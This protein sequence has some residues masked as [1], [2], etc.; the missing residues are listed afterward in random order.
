[1]AENDQRS[2][3]SLE[4]LD[5]FIAEG[6]SGEDIRRH[7]ETCPAC[8]DAAARLKANAAFLSSLPKHIG[9]ARPAPLTEP[10]LEIEGYEILEEIHRGGQGVV[11]RAIQKATN[12]TVALKIILSGAFATSR[13][14]HRFER[15]VELAAALRHSNI[16][17]VHDSGVSR[18]GRLYLAMELIDGESLDRFLL[19]A[20][21]KHIRD[22]LRLFSKICAA[23]AYAHQRG[24][25]HR[26]LKPGNIL[27]DEEGEP[28]IVD[29]GLAKGIEADWDDASPRVTM[30]GEFMGTLAYS[31]PE[32]VGG[33][34]DAIDVR[35]D[36]YSL[37]VI[38]YEALTGRHPYPVTGRLADVISAIAEAE[39]RPPSTWRKRP[40]RTRKR[41]AD[42]S[43]S[44]R[45]DDEI[46]TIILK[47]LA[48]DKERRYQSADHLKQDLDHYLAGE[49]I[50]AKRDSGWYVMRKAI[51]RHRGKFASAAAL[52]VLLIGFAVT[53]AVQRQSIAVE[54]D[55]ARTEAAKA[56]QINDFL[57]QMLASVDPVTARGRDVTIL[58]ELLD[59][60]ATRIE[61][62]LIGQPEVEAAVRNVIG[63]TYHA[64]GLYDE[65]EPHLTAAFDT[66]R[67]LKGDEHPDTLAVMHNLAMLYRAQGRYE[68]AEPVNVAVFEARRD[69]LGEEHPHTL[70]A[71]NE[72]ALL[73]S[74]QGRFDE[75]ERLHLE[76]DEIS[77]RVLGAD[78]PDTLTTRHNLANLYRKMGRYAQAEKICRETYESR[79]S[80]L[81][82]DHPET[83]SSLHLLALLCDDQS[84]YEEAASLTL[85]TLDISRRVQGPEHPET[86]V[87]A[88]NLANLLKHLARWDEAEELYLETL[89]IRRD[90]LGEGHP[91]TLISMN[92]LALLYQMQGR[93]DKAEPLCV[94]VLEISRRVLGDE[95][96]STV[97]YL[98]NLALLMARLGRNDEAAALFREALVILRRTLGKEHRNTLTTA[99]SLAVVYGRMGRYEEAEALHL[100]A[101]RVK[102][103]VLG[104]A[105]ADTLISLY[106]LAK[107]Y[108]I[109]DRLDEAESM[110]IECYD[111]NH[112]VF[113]AEHTETVDAIRLLIE[114]YDARGDA[115]AV[116]RWRE[117]LPPADRDPN[118]AS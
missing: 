96:P 69:L 87:T 106:S 46:E 104:T 68:E 16:V 41:D 105:H 50:D 29:F 7:L 24:V 13:Q 33:I 48:K 70:A 47:A 23:V 18:D 40:S 113:G 100:D 27:I 76:D 53:M 15:E 51:R 21:D 83:I 67:R 85:R 28:H 2:C 88:Q 90:H 45:I 30:T 89:R 92:D 43:L 94:E 102:Q 98:N 101:L 39:P 93:Y 37:G 55:A 112:Q 71:M 117:L 60:A 49:P 80:A 86:L 107:L 57:Q 52:V 8:A 34:P 26:D 84:R 110:A 118:D 42:D 44:S 111:G 109:T 97:T 115:D 81:G 1:V 6:E 38:L 103:R 75:A 114:V 25:I 95:H 14:R 79:L 35:S 74:K 78:H 3:P 58:R 61:T 62:E 19:A 82:E 36:V 72:L 10:G 54:R 99:S 31:S 5:A 20:R 77:R 64:I 4:E 91:D 11:Y 66:R 65:A 73:Y 108:V 59:D 32:H 116:Q 22:V 17:T 9:K 56:E 12:R 63:A